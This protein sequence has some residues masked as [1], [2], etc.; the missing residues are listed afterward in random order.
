LGEGGSLAKRA[1]KLLS[2]QVG[3]GLM[4]RLTKQFLEQKQQFRDYA[5]EDVTLKIASLPAISANH[6]TSVWID[7]VAGYKRRQALSL[8]KQDTLDLAVSLLRCLDSDQDAHT[9]LQQYF[10]EGRMPRPLRMD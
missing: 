1:V 7:F 8:S 5:M 2:F 9:A 10:T 3:G 6:G 4:A